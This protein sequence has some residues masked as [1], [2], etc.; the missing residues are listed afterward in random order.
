MEEKERLDMKAKRTLVKNAAV[1]Y[2]KL[3]KGQRSEKIAS[4][5]DATGWSSKH[6]IKQINKALLYGSSFLKV[7]NKKVTRKKKYHED[8]LPVIIAIWKASRFQNTRALHVMRLDWFDKMVKFDEFKRVDVPRNARE[9]L[10]SMSASTLERFIKP[11]RDKYTLLGKSTTKSGALLRNSIKV[12]KAG[13]EQEQAAGFTEVDTVAHCGAT[14]R[15]EFARTITQT[16]VFTGWTQLVAIRNNAHS[17]IRNG[18]EVLEERFPFPITGFDTDNGSE[19]IN[20]EIVKWVC[21]RD[22]YFTRSRPYK[23]NDNAHVE[24]KNNDLVR[25]LAFYFRYDTAEELAILNELYIC[26]CKFYNYFRPVQKTN[27]YRV[28]KVGKNVRTYDNPRTSFQRVLDC[29]ALSESKKKEML[30]EYERLNPAELSRQIF[31]LQKKL[32]GYAKHKPE[33]DVKH[34][35]MYSSFKKLGSKNAPKEVAA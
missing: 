18:L 2:R 29:N 17:N 21:D 28:S 10:E 4:L 6:A 20:Y 25:R 27:G 24:Q 22:L 3:S 13:D 5:C 16:D 12:R 9:V 7:T 8:I 30:S 19:F 11:I 15:G 33:S 35:E 34:Q 1:G 23:K 31:A 14:L 26:A 32:I